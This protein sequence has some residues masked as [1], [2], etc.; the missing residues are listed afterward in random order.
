MGS[1]PDTIYYFK[2][3]SA[4]FVPSASFTANNSTNYYSTSFGNL[5]HADSNADLPPFITLLSNEFGNLTPYANN[6][7]QQ[8]Q[9]LVIQRGGG[10]EQTVMAQ[11]PPPPNNIVAEPLR[12][13]NLRYLDEQQRN[14]D[15]LASPCS[16]P[17]F[18]LLDNLMGYN[19]SPSINAAPGGAIP[20]DFVFIEPVRGIMKVNYSKFFK[21]FN[22]K[23]YFL[24]KD[25]VWLEQRG[26]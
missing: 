17:N 12:N 4:A 2:L 7:N 10:N 19:G 8:Q 20:D 23:L 13:K 21:L 16:L 18:K 26:R 24:E 1:T 25:C 3:K 15:I 5:A 6:N 22:L 11:S 9:A 14:N